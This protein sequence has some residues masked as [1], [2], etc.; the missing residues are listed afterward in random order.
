MDGRILVM[1]NG[2]PRQ[3]AKLDASIA[4]LTFSSDGS[5]LAASSGEGALALFHWPTAAPIPL[6]AI[7][8]QEAPGLALLEP[9]PKLVSASWDHHLA[10]TD[11]KASNPAPAVWSIDGEPLVTVT[12]PAHHVALVLLNSGAGWL[13]ST[14]PSQAAPVLHV[15]APN[16]AA[17][18]ADGAMVAIGTTTGAVSVWDMQNRRKITEFHCSDSAIDALCFSSNGRWLAVGTEDHEARI[19][20]SNSGLPISG[21]MPH[22]GPVRQL[23]FAKGDSALITATFDGM[24]LVWPLATPDA[25]RVEEISRRVVRDQTGGTRFIPSPDLVFAPDNASLQRLILTLRQQNA[26]ALQS[27]IDLLSAYLDSA[28]TQRSP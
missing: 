11:P 23:T 17:F 28:T 9:G 14:A 12:D 16:C 6:P 24:L 7:H 19:Y 3:I 25:A 8:T 20:Q 2:H 26:P 27:Q 10:I 18:S 15:S 21:L 5:L 1:D 4:G 22:S 13:V